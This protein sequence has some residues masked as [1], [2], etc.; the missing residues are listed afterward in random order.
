[1][2]PEEI[3]AYAEEVAKKLGETEKKPLEQIELL[4]QHAGK[5]FVDANVAESF[6]I[7][8]E[9]GMFTE[10]KK[11]RRTVGGIFFYIAKGKLEPEMRGNIFPGYGQNK[12]VGKVVAWDERLDYVKPLLEGGEHG[13][14]RFVTVTLQ[15]RPGKVVIEDNSVM[16]TIAHSHSQT[17]LPRGVPHPPADTTLYTVYMAHKQY[18]TVIE[19]LE[20]YKNDWMLV[21]GTL[22][23][24]KETATMTVLATRVSTKRMDKMTKRDGEEEEPKKEAKPARAPKDDAK[25]QPKQMK[26]TPP[27]KPLKPMKPIPQ[28]KPQIEVSVP[29]GTPPDVAEK[30]RQL[31]SAAE[32]L[33]ERI[34]TMEE[35]GQSGV[36]MTKKLLMNTER[37]IEALE[38]QFTS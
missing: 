26:G 23:Y 34:A 12:P 5:E 15:G 9:G 28:P 27:P 3:K 35:K 1:M 25:R 19:S 13:E 36:A 20:K 17:P 7:E 31:Y 8:E 24:D 30:L 14:M 21:E 32:T 2:Q 18:E 37:Q 38:K 16:T 33:R 6:K 22:F 10:D 29:A 11:R 4:L